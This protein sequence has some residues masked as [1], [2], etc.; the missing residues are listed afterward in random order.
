VGVLLVLNGCT[1]HCQVYELLYG[2]WDYY[3]FFLC[4]LRWE[5]FSLNTFNSCNYRLYFLLSPPVLLGI[6]ARTSSQMTGLFCFFYIWTLSGLLYFSILSGCTARAEWLCFSFSSIWTSS[7]VTGLFLFFVH[8]DFVGFLV[9]P[10]LS[11]C[12]ARV[13]WLHFSASTIWTSSRMMGFFLCFF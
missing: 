5:Y 9:L 13:E 1:S 8:L 11:G 2:W 7:R 3:C 4:E 10:I 12:T 6:T